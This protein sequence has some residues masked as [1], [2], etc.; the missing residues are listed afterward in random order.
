[1]LKLDY[2]RH[3]PNTHWLARPIS[4]PFLPTIKYGLAAIIAA[5]YV[6]GLLVGL[7]CVLD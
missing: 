5:G 6:I 3:D 4:I 1:M 7:A 2:E